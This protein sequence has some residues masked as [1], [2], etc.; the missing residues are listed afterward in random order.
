MMLTLPSA[1]AME[2]YQTNRCLSS[3]QLSS[4]I[5][6]PF[7]SE[8]IWFNVLC[9]LK[10]FFAH[11]NCTDRVY[12]LLELFCQLESVCPFSVDLSREQNVSLHITGA[13]WM[14]FIRTILSE[15]WSVVCGNPRRSEVMV[16]IKTSPSGTNNRATVKIREI[17]YFAG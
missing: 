9:I 16:I 7:V 14:F 1:A 5:T 2:I 6:F 13:R 10:Y 15:L 8:P 4:L 17:T 3:L 12:E 11:H